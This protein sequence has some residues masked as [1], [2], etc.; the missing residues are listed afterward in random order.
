MPAI[1][2]APTSHCGSRELASMLVLQIPSA[3]KRSGGA[4]EPKG[5]RD[6]VSGG[7]LNSLVCGRALSLGGSRFK[8]MS[9]PDVII[10]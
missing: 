8:P 1:W 3:A 7:P 2:H 6:P 4:V 5:A 9:A 10:G